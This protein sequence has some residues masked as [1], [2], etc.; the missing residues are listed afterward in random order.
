MIQILSIDEL[1]KITRK[2]RSQL[3]Y[4]DF[5]ESLAAT[6][7]LWRRLLDT[8]HHPTVSD[9]HMTAVC[10]AVCFVVRVSSCS[11]DKDLKTFAFSGST[12]KDVF[13][14]SRS[15]FA[16]GKNKPALQVL[17]TLLHLAEANPDPNL[18]QTGVQQAAAEMVRIVFCQQ[19]RKALK[20]ASVV[21]YFFLRKL[22]DFMC[23]SDVLQQAYSDSR[24]TF[25]RRCRAA[26]IVPNNLDNQS[27]LQW[28]SFILSLLMVIQ[29]AESRS[30]TLKLLSLICTL[31][32]DQV[33][34]K[35][36]NLVSQALDCYGMAPEA[37]LTDVT[38]DVLPSIFV[39]QEQFHMFLSEPHS[40]TISDEPAVQL[41]LAQLKF[42][43][44]KIYIAE[45]GKSKFTK[46]A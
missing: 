41:L 46:I 24:L 15:A 16:S 5:S 19:P 36:V 10:N 45:T 11:P 42:G 28:Y 38:C 34:G 33:H 7:S 4:G 1:N 39:N 9:K 3:G 13:H 30:A 26:K 37:S 29:V 6:Q 32:N 22:S 35:I 17:D 25:L 31:R 27:D 20:E 21:L 8:V 40:N 14:V 18:V 12:W 23:F 43:R 44:S 2:S